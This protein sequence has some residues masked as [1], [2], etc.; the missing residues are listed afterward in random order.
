MKN[1]TDDIK[2]SASITKEKDLSV[3]FLFAFLSAP[4][5]IGLGIA[6][7]I[8]KFGDTEA[9]LSKISFIAE[10]ETVWLYLGLVVFG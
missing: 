7:A 5:M 6:Q 2:A 1:S 8:H 9:Y 3:M 4:L 10:N